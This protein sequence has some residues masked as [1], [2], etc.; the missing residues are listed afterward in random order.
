VKK[1]LLVLSDGNGVD[2]EFKKWPTLLKLLT[3]KQYNVINKSVVGASNDMILMQ[4]ADAVK[5]ENIDYA[6]VQWTIPDRLDVMA[7]PFWQEQAQNDSVYSFNIVNTNDLS[8]WVTSASTNPHIRLYHDCYVTYAH[9]TV[10]SQQLMLAAAELLKHHGI[11]FVF[12]L[13]YAFEF[14]EI[15]KDI[16]NSYPWVWHEANKGLHD[17]RFA[18]EFLPYD[19]GKPQPHTLIGLDWI[20][21]VLKPGCEFIDYDSQTYYNIQQSLL[22]NV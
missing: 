12:S 21:R 17:F 7:T 9:A 6:I 19:Q 16:L 2:N 14:T 4:I 13:C 10:K 22:K 18:S 1:N 20:E 3:T 8:W 11:E 5:N 15:Y